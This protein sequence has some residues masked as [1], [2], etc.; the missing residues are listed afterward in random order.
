MFHIKTP[1]VSKM[2]RVGATHI[3]WDDTIVY[4]WAGRKAVGYG[5]KDGRYGEVKGGIRASKEILSPLHFTIDTY[6]GSRL[7]GSTCGLDVLCV[8]SHLYYASERDETLVIKWGDD[9]LSADIFGK[10]K[11]LARKQD[12][13]LH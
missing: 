10:P 2:V 12:G 13:I 1:V 9:S 8:L 3:S 5:F 4:F 7:I 11:I 6:Y